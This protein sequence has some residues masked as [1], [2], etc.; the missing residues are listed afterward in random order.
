MAK[1][2]HS[3]LIFFILITTLA[4]A[5]YYA[6]EHLAS[7]NTTTK[8]TT[9][10]NQKST[11]AVLA[12]QEILIQERKKAELNQASSTQTESLVFSPDPV[13]NFMVSTKKHFG[14]VLYFAIQNNP[15]ISDNR[16]LY[17]SKIQKTYF[18]NIN[19][20]CEK[21]NKL[22]P[23]LQL[24]RKIEQLATD[25]HFKPSSLVGKALSK[26][27]EPLTDEEALDFFT[28]VAQ[29]YPD[30]ISYSMTRSIM[31]KLKYVNHELH[32]L[33]KNDDMSY[34]N[35][36]SRFALNLMAC[37]LGA[38]CGSSSQMMVEYCTGEE[39]FCVDSFMTLYNTRLS[40]GVKADIQLVLK[41]YKK[42]Y[43]V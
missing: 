18:D 6:W 21:L 2:N 24:D 31:Y 19:S 8:Q 9:G 14:C 26:R 32:K 7:D 15:E 16:E 17:Y 35:K 3:L 30:L 22:N 12:S 13:T 4:Y 29:D 37:E 10:K 27:R 28:Q 20:K 25:K 41:Y 34:H 40:Q 5:G 39:N 11:P 36:I 1:P 42:L 43:K 33:I 23:E 38:Y